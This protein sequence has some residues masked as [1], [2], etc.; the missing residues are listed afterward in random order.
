MTTSGVQ[1]GASVPSWWP[2]FLGYRQVWTCAHPTACPWFP[3]TN[4]LCAQLWA[5]AGNTEDVLKFL[6]P[7]T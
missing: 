2:A 5:G 6:S 4:L 1:G 7:R 3:G